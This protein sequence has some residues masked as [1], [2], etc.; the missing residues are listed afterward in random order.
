MARRSIINR[1]LKRGQLVA[2]FRE[3]RSKLRL[4]LK[5]L[6][7]SVEDKMNAQRKLQELPRDSC[8]VRLRNRCAITGRSRGFFRRFG[9]SR[10][11]IR[12][13]A[14]NGEIPGVTKSSW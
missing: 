7:A 10:N 2:R 12:D 1:N 6:D 3:Q 14:M 11:L 5:D 8:P 4:I 9:L 13:L